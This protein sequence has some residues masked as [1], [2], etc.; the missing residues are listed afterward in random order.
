M[1]AI[2]AGAFTEKQKLGMR[3]TDSLYHL[4]KLGDKKWNAEFVKFWRSKKM[5]LLPPSAIQIDGV[6]DTMAK[7]TCDWLLGHDPGV[8]YY[9]AAVS[10]DMIHQGGTSPGFDKGKPTK[11]SITYE[12]VKSETTPVLKLN[13]FVHHLIYKKG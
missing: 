8:A 6:A 2:R 7:S 1:D 3:Q 5:K 9:E 11:V 12:P 10:D 4:T 13:V